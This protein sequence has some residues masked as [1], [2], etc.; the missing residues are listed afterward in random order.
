MIFYNHLKIQQC[1]M[2]RKYRYCVIKGMIQRK[3]ATFYQGKYGLFNGLSACRYRNS[4]TGQTGAY[5]T[6]SEQ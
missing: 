5:S 3:A 2:D 1:G 4:F 6:L